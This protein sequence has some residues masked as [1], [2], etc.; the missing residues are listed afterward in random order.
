M[1]VFS[2]LF[3]KSKPLTIINL[4]SYFIG[5]FS[6]ALK[7]YSKASIAENDIFG[8]YLKPSERANVVKLIMIGL[9]DWIISLLQFLHHFT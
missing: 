5:L 7:L 4:E 3:K 8:V 1:R 2:K 9:F 6:V